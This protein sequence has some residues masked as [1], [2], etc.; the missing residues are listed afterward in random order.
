MLQK[1]IGER[2]EKMS[3]WTHVNGSIRVDHLRNISPD[4]N[5]DSIFKEA[6]WD[7]EDWDNCNIPCGE[8]GSLSVNIWEDPHQSS[9][10]AYTVNIFGDLRGYNDYEEIVK[11]FTNLVTKTF[12]MVRDAVI[13]ISV[14][15][16]GYM[17]LRLEENDEGDKTM[18]M[19][20]YKVP[21]GI[22][23]KYSLLGYN[24]VEI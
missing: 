9:M 23:A 5:F 14:E 11:W 13:T 10:A 2:L 3:Q 1:S 4:I 21:K 12:P 17:I 16:E 15:N 18:T 22:V 24:V 7:E 8:E 20:A 6:K 19:V